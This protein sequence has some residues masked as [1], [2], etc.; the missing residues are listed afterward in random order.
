MGWAK[1]YE[2]NVSIC[3]DRMALMESRPVIEKL[4]LNQKPKVVFSETEKS[5]IVK[6]RKVIRHKERGRRGLELR[7]RKLPDSFALR[8]LQMNGWWWSKNNSCWC[9]SD[10][11]GN[12]KNMESFLSTYGPVISI[13]VYSD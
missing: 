11:K 12:R 2:D 8:K 7:F 6:P 4:T 10:T 1:Y 9:N 13:V 3:I 5:D